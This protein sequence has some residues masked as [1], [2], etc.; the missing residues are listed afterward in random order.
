M[1]TRILAHGAYL[2]LAGRIA[3]LI[4]SAGKAQSP[5]RTITRFRRKQRDYFFANG[6][7][8]AEIMKLRD[9]NPFVTG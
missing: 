4:L 1:L 6:K 7:D 5:E 8:C 3:H 2:K 9:R